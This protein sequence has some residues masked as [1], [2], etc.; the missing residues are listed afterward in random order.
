MTATILIGLAVFGACA[1]E[2]V[3]ALTI[4]L[5]AGLTRGWRSALEGA[6]VAALC[7]AVIVLAFGPALVHYVPINVLRTVVGSLLLVL[8]LQWLRKAILRASGHKA[9]HDED[10]I[11]RREVERLSGIA[12]TGSGRDSIGF[13]ISFKGVLLEGLEVVMIVLTLGL[14]SGHLEVAALAALA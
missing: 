3:E 5:A 12:R 8:G 4:V 1:V 13:I 2:M 11:Y 10:A 9:K 6:A 7:L 14:S